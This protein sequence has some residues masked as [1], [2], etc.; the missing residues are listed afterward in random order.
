MFPRPA[1]FAW[2]SFALILLAISLPANAYEPDAILSVSPSPD[3]KY[4]ALAYA[5]GELGV[6]NL[7]DPE[8]TRIYSRA[9]QGDSFAW[10]PDSRRIAFVEQNPDQFCVLWM[11]EVGGGSP[12]PLIRGSDWKS[13]PGW[14]GPERLV[15]L[16]DLEA[17]HINLW[18]LELE[19]GRPERILNL[20]D[21]IS[22]LWVSPASS[23]MLV[24]STDGRESQLLRYDSDSDA[25]SR[26]P[27]DGQNE[28]FSQG[29]VT[30]SPD[31]RA[32]AYLTLG[33]QQA[34]L[35]VIE[36]GTMRPLGRLRMQRQPGGL[37]LANNGR[38]LLEFEGKL[39]RW[40]YTRAME[41]GR[42]SE[43][44]TD[45][46]EWDG[47]GFA[48][49]FLR[50]GSEWG[51]V[52]K[53]NIVMTARGFGDP[54]EAR[55]HARSAR[56]L[57]NLG[58]AW[59]AN[60][61]TRQARRTLE[62]LW[63]ATKKQPG[64]EAFWIALAR[65][66]LER[67]DRDPKRAIRWIERAAELAGDDPEHHAALVRERALLYFFDREDV[68]ATAELID[69]VPGERSDTPLIHWMA[70]LLE[71]GEDGPGPQWQ[72]IGHELRRG[73]WRDVAAEIAELTRADPTSTHLRRG[74]ALL[75]SGEFEPLTAMLD[76]SPPE[77][78]SL[79]AIPSMQ[80]VLL[81]LSRRDLSPEVDKNELRGLLLL[82]WAKSG[83]REA[84][85]S[86]VARDLRDPAGSSLDYL[87]MLERYLEP[88]ELDQWMELAVGEILLSPRIVPLLDRHMLDTRAH[89][90][91]RLARAKHAL[92]QGDTGALDSELLQ[93]EN[94]LVLISPDF[95]DREN[96]RLL[97]LPRLYRAKYF[98]RLGYWGSAMGAYEGC[99]EIIHRFPGD[100]GMYA[101]DLVWARTLV[102]EGRGNPEELNVY[103]QVIRG[104]GDPLINPAHEETTVRAGLTNLTTLE[105]QTTTDWL[106]PFLRYARGVSLGQLERPY[107]SVAM[108]RQ[109]RAREIPTGLKA[110]VLV[111]EAAV[112]SSLRQ[113]RLAVDLLTELCS[114][115]LDP[116]SMTVA[117]QIRAQ[118]EQQAG[119]V[120]SQENRIRYLCHELELPFAWARTLIAGHTILPLEGSPW[121]PHPLRPP[122]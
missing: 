119:L 85:R 54:S 53:S 79:L 92:I 35:W 5:S 107:A 104:L 15:Y 106:P 72:E 112:R 91:F 89:L 75:L 24:A 25:W 109:A 18:S 59:Q 10:A 100:W 96:A 98:E 27:H 42:R 13:R 120:E 103:L 4:L 14:A 29:D 64:G 16:S 121:P 68:R 32:A 6:I 114:L 70:D 44:V 102:A 9:L 51:A 122:A 43:E 56:D 111:E 113:Y 34:D 46:L 66:Q 55:F 60:G 28:F 7:M 39:H 69:S 117:I 105:R 23:E 101:P 108:L 57:V 26:L 90:V 76:A 93:I 49:P 62:D 65:A 78:E 71:Q 88:D 82:L 116:A 86:L 40:D 73:D 118:A 81:E 45:I 3:G 99:M 63:T 38:V 2:H 22:G 80:Q 115:D 30:F 95:W 41:S 67:L 12:E 33:P 74:I 94:D 20:A 17:D 84:A 83:E 87:D 77:Y 48:F 11:V 61:N 19:A 31:G 37:A 58:L 52:I 47:P 21:D 110:R 50:S 36:L 8:A 1:P 97:M